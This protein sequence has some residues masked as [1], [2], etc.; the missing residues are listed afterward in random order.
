MPDESDFPMKFPRNSFIWKK[1]TTEG[2]GPGKLYSHCMHFYQPINSILIYGGKSDG[3]IS[4]SIQST[5]HIIRMDN[6]NWITV[7]T[8]G[9][10]IPKRASFASTIAGSQ[11]IVFG[12]VKENFN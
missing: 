8:H 12:G 4:T 10:K 1:V 5:I 7:E 11:L 3:N 9:H 2:N 6:L